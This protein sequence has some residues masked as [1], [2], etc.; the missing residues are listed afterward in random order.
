MN[1]AKALFHL[2]CAVCWTFIAEFQAS[3]SPHPASSAASFGAGGLAV[4]RAVESEGY[5]QRTGLKHRDDR[6]VDLPLGVGVD[7]F[8]RRNALL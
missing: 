8:V 1:R 6:S 7:L 5:F 2:A 3:S 4:H